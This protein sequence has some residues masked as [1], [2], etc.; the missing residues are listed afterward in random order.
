[1]NA[2]PD[3]DFARLRNR[4]L[5]D[6]LL[7][8]GIASI[9]S[10]ILS[11]AR[12]YVLGLR[13]LMLLHVM[14]V[15]TLW[16]MW[17][18][19]QRISYRT[20][21][22]GLLAV[23][24]L[25][26]F[27]GLAQL[28]PV[29][30]GG[31]FIILFAF[32]AILFLGENL[33]WWLIAANGLCMALFGIATTLHWLEFD[34][35]YQIYAHNPVVWLNIVWTI[36]AYSLIFALFGWRMIE[37]L[38]QRGD[39]LKLS[40]LVYQ[41]SSEA[42]AIADADNRII[43]INPAFTDMMGYTLDEVI[44]KNPN[45]LSS[46]RQDETFYR[47]MWGKLNTVGRWQGEVWNRRK[48]GDFYA[49][50]LTINTIH[51]DDGS[52]YRRVALF[53]D[54][55]EKKKNDELIWQQANFDALTNLPNRRMAHDRLEQEIKKSK[56]KG[57]P[58]ALF[59]IDLD[60]FKEVNDTLGH[61]MGDILLQEAAQ[62][63]ISCVRNSDTVAR[64]GGDEFIIILSELDD[65]SSIERIADNLLI[66]LAAPFQLKR[67]TGCIS[68]SIGITLYPD[69]ATDVENMLKN[70]DQAMYAAKHDG[71][72]RFRYYSP[73]LQAAASARIRN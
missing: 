33:A 2:Q 70:A 37:W 9:P 39:E 5:N 69:N 54:I 35:D 28:G 51:N 55:T 50:R 72:N 53:S 14:L 20:R 41:T 23:L 73:A 3:N 25:A 34:L 10:A 36:T 48:N 22:L 18:N 43:T 44:G 45:I 62:R 66:K 31:L 15:G 49:A 68:A 61:D 1:M 7:W 52:I 65:I 38:L 32:I 21:V 11:L 42:I 8:V 59:L 30:A 19:H 63:M 47:E 6:T 64:L 46:G 26:A 57:L 17:F 27:A 12:F 71:R 40:S 29:A 24:W 56:R 4:L 16:L 67:E 58:V 13:P 60:Q